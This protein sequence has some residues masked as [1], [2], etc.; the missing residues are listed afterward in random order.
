MFEIPSCGR[1]RA[2]HS[3][4]PET[5]QLVNA[6]PV[7]ARPGPVGLRFPWVVDISGGILEAVDKSKS[8]LGTSNFDWAVEFAYSQPQIDNR[9]VK[10]IRFGTAKNRGKISTGDRG[11]NR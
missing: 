1:G 2:T 10:R 8:I 9:N 7:I 6:Y 11:A 4:E 5:V 3:G